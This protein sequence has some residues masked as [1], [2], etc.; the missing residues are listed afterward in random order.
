MATTYYHLACGNCGV[1]SYLKSTFRQSAWVCPNCG[2]TNVT[3][4]PTSPTALHPPLTTPGQ[5]NSIV[6]APSALTPVV[7]CTDATL[8]VSNW[9]SSSLV[10]SFATSVSGSPNPAPSA[11]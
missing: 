8:V 3:S 11:V 4:V 10:G 2:N 5:A 6:V 7:T 1:L 9:A